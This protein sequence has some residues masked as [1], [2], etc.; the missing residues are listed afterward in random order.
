MRDAFRRSIVALVLG[1]LSTGATCTSQ[2]NPGE[3]LHR[4]PS[5]VSRAIHCDAQLLP[6]F[7]VD[8]NGITPPRV[9]GGEKLRHTLIYSMCPNPDGSTLRGRLVRRVRRGDETI[10]EDVTDPFELKP[11]R[12]I[13]TAFVRVPPEAEPGTYTFSVDIQAGTLHYDG[14]QRFDIKGAK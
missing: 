10:L 2:L 5:T 13:V 7:V 12:W 1:L 3:V 14:T 9:A 4:S 6:F 11:G 8:R